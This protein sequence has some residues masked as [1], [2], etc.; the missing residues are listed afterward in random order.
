MLCNSCEREKNDK[1]VTETTLQTLR[2]VKKDGEEVLHVQKFPCSPWIAHAGA[3]I[4][5]HGEEAT[6]EQAV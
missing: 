5:A 3:G 2:S 4:M 6:Q 1:N